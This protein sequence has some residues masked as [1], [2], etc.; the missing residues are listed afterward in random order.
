MT[1]IR[2]RRVAAI[3]AVLVLAA[4]PAWAGPG[5]VG[6]LAKVSGASPLAACTADN[7]AGQSGRNV[8]NSEVEPWIASSAVDR[9]GDGVPDLIAGYQ[10]DRWSNGGA[11]GVFASVFHNGSWQQVGIPGVSTCL[12]GTELRATDPWVTIAPDGTAY[13]MTLSIGDPPVDPT[14]V[15]YVNRSTDGGLTWGPPIQLIRD[16]SFFLFNDKNSMTADPFD[17]HFVYAI[18]DRSRF[19]SDIRRAPVAGRRAA[20]VPQRRDVH[21]HHGRRR[22]LGAGQGDLPAAGEPVRHRAPDRGAVRRDPRRRVHALPRLRGQQEGPGNRRSDLDRPWR[23]PGPSPITV[24]KALPGFVND[25]DDGFPLRT[26]DIIPEIA[27]GPDGSVYMVWQ[28]ATLAPSGSAIAF[29]KSLD[30][31]FTWSASVRINT[32]P[33][34]PGVHTL[35]RGPARRHHRSHPLRPAQ[36]HTG[37]G[38]VANRLLVPALPRRRRNL[39]RNPGHPTSFDGKLAPVARGPVPRRLHG[40]GRA[41]RRVHGRVHPDRDHRPSKH[42]RATAHALTRDVD[43]ALAL[44]DDARGG[45]HSAR[46][47]A[48]AFPGPDAPMFMKPRGAGWVGLWR[49]SGRCGSVSR[50]LGRCRA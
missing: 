31:G 37:P 16:A 20:L 9:S 13:F 17:S 40:P 38:D 43:A 2:Y 24:A 33:D 39:D 25:P 28:E 44:Y 27:A 1:R 41:Q 49:V 10:Q 46:P 18:W 36:Q 34:V 50:P 21:P 6:P 29:S 11:R 22:V 15:L 47:T 4:S 3:A 7:V 5:S 8:A 14:S 12:G 32:R 23:R 19:P 48:R 35:D 45:P 42:L 30:G 26:G